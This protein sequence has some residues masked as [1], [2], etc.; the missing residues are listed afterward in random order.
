M[1]KLLARS[2]AI[3]ASATMFALYARVEL[4]W[5]LLGWVGLV[6]WL[7][8]LDR[9][10]STTS[11]IANGAAMSAAFTLGVFAWFASAVSRYTELSPPLAFA[12]LALAA[13]VLQPQFLVFAAAR[14]V[15]H[16]R[17]RGRTATAVGAACAWVATEWACPR[18]F[19]DTIGHGL[20][21]FATLRQGADLA[22]AAGL[23]FVILL[24]N[25]ALHAAL[26]QS[27]ISPRRALGAAA[28]ALLLVA[29][30]ASYGS[31]RLQQ[32]ERRAETATGGRSIA[33]TA[34]LVQANLADYQGL[35]RRLGELG[36]VREILD[37]HETMSRRV[38]VG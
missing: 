37:T 13:P 15:L 25:Q 4:P 12:L 21:P 34:A 16:A 23:S 11:A 22:G 2:V 1:G 27:R 18:L 33:L 8:T 24:V 35:R 10:R 7:A 20:L 38:L 26:Q 14:H 30:L 9:E 5:A 32:V 36:A 6:P 31:L 3:L 17:G 28:T 19:A 29:A